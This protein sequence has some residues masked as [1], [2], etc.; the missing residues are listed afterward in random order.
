MFMHAIIRLAEGVRR[1][2]KAW[3]LKTCA[4][5]TKMALRYRHC[6]RC[7]LKTV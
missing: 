4:D 7:A 3:G 2:V 6:N 5:F 1:A